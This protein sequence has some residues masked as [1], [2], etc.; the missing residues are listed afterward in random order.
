[1]VLQL[2]YHTTWATPVLK[3]SISPRAATWARTPCSAAA[4]RSGGRIV[5]A[6]YRHLDLRAGC[7]LANQPIPRSCAVRGTVTIQ[8]PAS[9]HANLGAALADIYRQRGVSGLWHGTGLGLCR[10]QA[11][12]GSP[13]WQPK[14]LTGRGWPELGAACAAWPGAERAG[15]RAGLSLSQVGLGVRLYLPRACAA[16]T[17]PLH[18]RVKRREGSSNVNLYKFKV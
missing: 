5:A 2:P 1:M 4:T 13:L 7:Q 17:L 6:L 18:R 14:R 15:T 12:C 16:H 8:N 3:P 10:N 9:T 11:R